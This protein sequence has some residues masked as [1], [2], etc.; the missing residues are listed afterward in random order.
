M[1]QTPAE[2]TAAAV[3]AELGRQ[4]ITG[5]GLARELGWAF[6]T[7]SRRLSG[8]YPFDVDELAQVARYLGVPITTLIADD[9]EETVP[10]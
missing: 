1:G 7:T 8:Q 3:R 6:N 2:R 4:R 9:D 5:R 10:V